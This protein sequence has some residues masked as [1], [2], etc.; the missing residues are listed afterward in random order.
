MDP[1]AEPDA[2]PTTG[3]RPFLRAQAPDAAAVAAELDKIRASVHH[4]IGA[5]EQQLAETPDDHASQRAKRSSPLERQEIE[6]DR[7]ALRTEIE[8]REHEWD[9]RL[10]ALERD[11]LLLA[12][13]W[14]RLECEQLAAVGSSRAATHSGT[15]VAVD[16]AP[17]PRS[18]PPRSD[19][20][21][22]VSRAILR[23]FES[24]R[25]DVRT[26]AGARRSV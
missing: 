3:G 24:L 9:S 11:R 17:P 10:E 4:W 14:E 1:D 18:E 7:E 5:I 20:E 25:Q 2:D 13:A 12:E 8:R 16:P 26:Q 21:T 15:A 22:A 6:R 19:S 23:Q